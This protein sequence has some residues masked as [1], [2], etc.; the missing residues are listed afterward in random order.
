MEALDKLKCHNLLGWS[1]QQLGNPQKAVKVLLQA[2]SI[3]KAAQGE[4]SPDLVEVYH[5]LALVYYL[6]KNWSEA[7]N[8]TQFKARKKS[9]LRT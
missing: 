4:G 9:T 5:Y 8:T 1:L 7:D 3:L 2:A 6:Q